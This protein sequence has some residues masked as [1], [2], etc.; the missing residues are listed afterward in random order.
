MYKIELKPFG[1]QLTF[2]DVVGKPELE[3]WL[4]ES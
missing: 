3:K 2:A 1:V 4:A